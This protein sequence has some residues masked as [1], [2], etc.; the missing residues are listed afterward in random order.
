MGSVQK[1]RLHVV[2]GRALH[3]QAFVPQSAV[4]EGH[5]LLWTTLCSQKSHVEALG[6]DGMVF[7]DGAFGR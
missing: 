3:G 7:G 4:P 5:L 1:G 2:H 6:L